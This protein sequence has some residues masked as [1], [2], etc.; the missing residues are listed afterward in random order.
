MKKISLLTVLLLIAIV[1]FSDSKITRGPNVGEI[2]FIG[3]T[4]TGLGLYYSTD[5]GQ[6]AI[7]VDSTF[8]SSIM[9][10]CADK[11]EGVIYYVTMQTS[12]YYSDDYGQL[13]SWELRNSGIKIYINSGRNE[14]EIYSNISKKSIDYGQNFYYNTCNGYFGEGIDTEIDNMENNGYTCVYSIYNSDTIFLLHSDDDFENVQVIQEFNY[15][16]SNDVDISRGLEPGELYFMNFSLGELYY[17]DDFC[18]EFDYTDSFNFS[19]DYNI[20]LV[21]GQQSGELFLIYNFVNQ[22]WINAHIYIY[23]STNYGKTFEVYHPFY[24]GNEPVLAN[25]STISKEIHLTTPVE[26]SNF[27]IG[28]IFEYQWDFDNDGAI[29]SFD[30]SPTYIYQDTGWYSVKLSVVGQDSTNSFVK[31]NYIHV[32]DTTTKITTNIMS[33]ISFSPNPFE[34]NLTISSTNSYEYYSISIY[35]L[36]GRKVFETYKQNTESITIN[37]IA[38]NPGVYI[39]NISS[40]NNSSNYKII[41]K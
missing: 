28:N 38:L 34:N 17:S 14:G 31:Q 13:G 35:N 22:M 33:S 15:H 24:K 41:K 27:S 36:K 20:E 3:P 6:T 21:G 40:Q 12:L 16:W 19:S 18:Q 8:T 32:I 30:E 11:T 1:S 37:T 23:H 7:C 26:F 5:F 29:D 4:H 9:S 39:L 2:Y 10:I 25:F